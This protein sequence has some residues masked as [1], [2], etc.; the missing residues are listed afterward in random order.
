MPCGCHKL[1]ALIDVTN[2]DQQQ[3]VRALENVEFGDWVKLMRC[4]V[5]GQYWKVDEWDK[6]Q[7]LYAFKIPDAAI[8]KSVDVTPFVKER[9]IENRGGLQEGTCMAAGCGNRAVVGSAYC[10]DHLYE[11][12]WRA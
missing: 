9:I 10:V 1:D 5:C 7:T 6:Y 4:P 12:G 11:I 8:W 3:F 2:N